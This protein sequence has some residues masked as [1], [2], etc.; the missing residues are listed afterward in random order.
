MAFSF[1]QT[2]IVRVFDAFKG[3]DASAT[4]LSHDLAAKIHAVGRDGEI[5]AVGTC[6]DP[7]PPSFVAFFLAQVYHGCELD[8]TAMR[9]K[10]SGA[11]LILITRRLPLTEEL[12]KDLAF[13]DLDNLLFKSPENAE[14]FPLKVF[15]LR[16]P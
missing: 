12:E 9:I 13:E 11:K 15:Q 1:V 10:S 7:V 16:T 5:A 8:S 2:P 4:T 6:L 3:L 14:K